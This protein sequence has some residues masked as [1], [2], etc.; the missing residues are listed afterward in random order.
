[1]LN[2]SGVCLSLLLMEMAVFSELQ[3]SHALSCGALLSVQICGALPFFCWCTCISPSLLGLE[4]A[5]RPYSCLAVAL[6]PSWLS[7][8]SPHVLFP[9]SPFMIPTLQPVS[10]PPFRIS[11]F[12]LPQ[13]AVHFSITLSAESDRFSSFC[14]HCWHGSLLP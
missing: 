13:V 11:F 14:F 1:M 12:Q 10:G 2:H 8:F 3:C 4:A 6:W 7:R 9:F 5:H